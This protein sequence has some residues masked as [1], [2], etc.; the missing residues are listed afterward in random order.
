MLQY[1][2][3]TPLSRL[4][5]VLRVS[6]ASAVVSLMSPG[7]PAPLLQR[8]A[9]CLQFNDI[10]EERPGLI[11]PDRGHVT[12]LLDF[13][14][15]HASAGSLIIHCYAGISR[16]PAAAFIV[17]A[18]LW[19]AEDEYAL[20]LALRQASASAT[21][22]PRLVALA[23]AYLGRNGRMIEA[24]RA[25]GRGADAYEGECFRLERFPLR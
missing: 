11:A 13:A 8:P 12:A 14:M 19:P 20:A 22:N 23:D 7:T 5:E 9:L 15:L 17:A 18:A 4:D 1:I 10:A 2:D 24:I 6:R 16:S 3:I 21:P 25:I